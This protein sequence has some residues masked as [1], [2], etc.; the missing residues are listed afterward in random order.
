MNSERTNDF[1]QIV[2]RHK[3]SIYSICYMF[4]ERKEDADDLLQDVL[5][6]LWNGLADFRDEARI[7][8]WIYRVSMNTCISYKRKKRIRTVPLEISSDFIDKVASH[9]SQPDILRKRISALAPIDRA[10][11][12]LWLENLPYDEIASIIGSTPKAIG[13]RLVRI[14]EKLKET[15]NKNSKV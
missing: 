6:N 8:T 14:K 2:M 1:Q 3:S 11:V 10:I 13:L 9:G 4:V 15:T 7:E 12:L 5:I